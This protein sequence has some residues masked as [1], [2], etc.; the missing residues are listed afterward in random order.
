M[1]RRAAIRAGRGVS[2]WLAGE[3][4][5]RLASAPA[6][7]PHDGDDEWNARDAAI[8]EA[9]VL[10]AFVD[11]P[12]PTLLLTRRQA[13]MRRHSGQVAFPGG[14][15][16][17]EDADL[18]ATALREAE[19]EVAL[20]RG[21]VRIIGAVP[22]YGTITGYR[23]TPILAVIPPDLPLTPQPD[24]VARVFEARCDHLFD[25]VR[26]ERRAVD[27]EGRVRHYHEIAAEG[28]RVWGATAGMIRNIGAALGLDADPAALNRRV[29]A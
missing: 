12:H 28:E 14:R 27:W 1:E 19:E 25:P 21:S 13:M 15:A 3:L 9:A 20:P 8:A 4:A 18:I 5:R 17:P 24:E 7:I 16:D 11:R 26:Q 6:G 2:D 22:P 10:V 23:V 29:P